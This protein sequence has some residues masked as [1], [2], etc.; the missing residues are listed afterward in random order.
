M[1][2]VEGA[3]KYVDT[4][5]TIRVGD[6]V[7]Y[8][9]EPGVIVFIVDDDSYSKDYERQHWSYLKRGFGFERVDGTLFHLDEPDEDL[10]PIV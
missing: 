3:M 2:V 9:G 5:Q 1:F 7:T 4:D 6:H 10:E 8:C